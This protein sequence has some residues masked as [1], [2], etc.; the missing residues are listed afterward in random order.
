VIDVRADYVDVGRGGLPQVDDVRHRPAARIP[1]TRPVPYI[2]VV[3]GVVAAHPDVAV[4]GQRVDRLARFGDR[5]DVGR[6]IVNRE[7]LLGH[8]RPEDFR[9]SARVLLERSHELR[10]HGAVEEPRGLRRVVAH[11]AQQARLV[12]HLHHNHRAVGFVEFLEVSE[13]RRVRRPIGF[14][15]GLS[16]RGKHA[17]GFAA[18]I[19]H[20]REPGGIGLHPCGRVIHGPVFPGAEPQ[21]NGSQVLLAQAAQDLVEAAEVELALHRFDGVPVD[22]E[23]DG[24]GVQ[25]FELGPRAPHAVRKG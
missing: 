9:P 12:L 5:V 6:K 23:L 14:Q 7:G 24:V 22:R 15:C 11:A 21:Q 16:V 19:D 3:V 17:D 20:A 13:Q 8:A 4:G 18:G 1:F 2:E 10:G 25:G